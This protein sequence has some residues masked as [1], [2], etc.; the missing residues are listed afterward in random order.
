[1]FYSPVLLEAVYEL[2]RQYPES[3]HFE[4]YETQ[5]DR[6]KA[7][8]EAGS[9]DYEKA[10]VIKK[11]YTSFRKLLEQFKGQN[12]LV[13]IW[14]TWCGPCI[15]D[16][17]FKDSLKPYIEKNNL[18]IIYISIDKSEWKDKWE[19]SIKYNQLEGFHVRANNELIS[20]MW[21]VIGDEKG[22]VPRYVLIDSNGEIFMSTAPRPLEGDELVNKINQMLSKEIQR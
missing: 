16:F 7:S 15:E 4:Y 13:D 8:I 19:Q 17:R 9:R 1:M 20:D 12:L 14:A 21:T 10:V 6:L 11:R 22:A 18:K 5:I 2:Q 3:K